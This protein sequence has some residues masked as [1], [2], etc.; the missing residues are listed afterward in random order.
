MFDKSD[1]RRRNLSRAGVIFRNFAAILLAVTLFCFL[2]TVLVY[3][4][5]IVLVVV[6]I[7]TFGTLFFV[8]EYRALFSDS[9]AVL[10]ILK[11]FNE[12]LPYIIGCLVLFSVLGIIFSRFDKNWQK[13]KSAKIAS[14][15][16]LILGVISVLIY[17]FFFTSLIFHPV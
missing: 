17:I 11:G 14:I 7:A 15:I 3:V 9:T 5:F 4:F 12:Y 10:D 1:I 8:P 2:S 16:F 13:A 6:G